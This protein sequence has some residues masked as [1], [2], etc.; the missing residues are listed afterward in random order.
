MIDQR[1]ES[2][3]AVVHQPVAESDDILNIDPTN[4]AIVARGVSKNFGP[5]QALSGVNVTVNVNSIHAFVGANGAGKSTLLGCIAGRLLPSSGTIEVM[6]RALSYGDPRA[7][8]QAG[9]ATVFQELTIIPAMSALENVFLGQAPSRHGL[10]AFGEMR[11][12]YEKLCAQFSVNIPGNAVAGSLSVADQ[13]MLEIMRCVQS[14]A[15]IFI[16]D[17]PTTALGLPERRSL[18]S[19]MRNLRDQGKALIIV[20]HNLEDVLEIADE[21]TV[22]RDGRVSRHAPIEQWTERSLVEAMLGRYASVQRSVRSLPAGAPEK[23]RIDN[24]AVDGGIQNFSVQIRRGEIVGLAGLVGSGRS[25]I[26][27]SLVGLQR[28]TGNLTLDGSTGSLPRTPREALS[29]G[30]ALIPEDR[31]IDGLVLDMTVADNIIITDLKQVSKASVISKRHTRDLLEPIVAKYGFD[32]KRL[33]MPVRQL[34]GGNQQKI[35]FSKWDYRT[36]SVLLID[37]PTRGVDVGSKSDILRTLQDLAGEGLSIL[38]VSSELEEIAAICN[39]IYTISESRVTARIDN[40]RDHVTADNILEQL[41][42][43]KP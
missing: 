22:F 32:P 21:I 19:T 23:L 2:G 25:S 39:T 20:S 40:D 31:K 30:F 5:V 27:R 33:G 13:Q 36:P 16:L 28:A 41:F 4:A 26:L 37:E 14:D 17:E 35:L 12:R 10:V 15:R 34:S 11:L 7:V 1:V 9:I 18:F 6:G 3:S 38:M 29:R 42:E 43:T 24:L 8:H